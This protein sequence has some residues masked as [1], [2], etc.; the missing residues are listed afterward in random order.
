LC[1]SSTKKQNST[2]QKPQRRHKT[3]L[4]VAFRIPFPLGIF[5]FTCRRAYRILL[6]DDN[7]FHPITSLE[8][9]V[10]C[11]SV[12]T[13]TTNQP[14]AAPTQRQLTKRSDGHTTTFEVGLEP[15]WLALKEEKRW[16]GHRILW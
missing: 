7:S 1:A 15:I 10:R 12:R 2:P 13:T 16:L 6:D 11:V 5:P 4:T 8:A 14:F 9:V 3:C